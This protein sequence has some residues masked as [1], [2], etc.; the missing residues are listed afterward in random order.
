MIFGLGVDIVQLVRMQTALERTPK[1]A[2]RILTDSELADFLHA[3]DRP[4]YLAKR[5]ASKE[6][7][8][9]A[10][11]T[12][13]AKGVSWH[14]IQIDKTVDGKPLVALTGKALSVAT[15][16]E[17]RAWHLSYSDEKEYVVATVI[18]ES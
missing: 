2:E 18:A 15:D 16:Y 1:L 11:G 4:R 8:V 6:A 3:K 9:K 5:F 12:G 13:I 17:I 10:L 14:D 7:V